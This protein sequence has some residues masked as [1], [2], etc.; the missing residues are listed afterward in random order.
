[1]IVVSES[2]FCFGKIITRGIEIVIDEPA[3]KAKTIHST[4]NIW[5]VVSEEV[6]LIFSPVKIETILGL[7][8]KIYGISWLKN[9][10]SRAKC[11][12]SIKS[13]ILSFLGFNIY[14]PGIT[15]RI[16]F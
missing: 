10:C 11:Y 3:V 4:E 7:G 6:Y 12:A 16:I 14:N 9:T 13:I 2:E 8:I 1:M 5:I 15:R